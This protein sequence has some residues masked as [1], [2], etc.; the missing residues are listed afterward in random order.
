[1]SAVRGS[2]LLVD[3]EEKILKRLGRALRDE[4]HEVVEASSARDAQRHLAERS[5]D[6]V[7]IDNVMPGMTGLEL[8]RELSAT[9][10]PKRSGRRWCMMTAHGST[11]IVR[12]AFKLGVEDF[13]EKPFEV[14]E[15]LALARRAV[16]S[17]RL[18]TREAVPD[19]RARRRVQPLRHRRPQ[20]ADAGRAAARRARG[21]DQ[22]HGAHHRRDRHRQGDGGAAHPPPQRAARH[23]A[24]QGE[25]R[26]DSRDA[27]RVGAL[28]PRAR[29]VHR[30][31]DDQARQVRAGRRR[32]DLP[33]RDRHDEH[34]RSRR[35]CCACCRSASSSRSAP[36]GRRRWTCASSPPPTAT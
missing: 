23:A 11:Q 31:H 5:F 26:G 34:R 28:R 3:D 12:D 36:S 6:L 32:L 14:D 8:M 35:S 27:A 4:G 20:P 2:I 22:E 13:L 1:M 33:R 29:R 7:V 9:M 19:Q 24:H 30:R 16:R 21:A 17:Q 10:Q 25:L 18:Q 15:L